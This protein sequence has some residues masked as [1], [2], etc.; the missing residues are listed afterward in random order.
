MVVP[1]QAKV[2][3]ITRVEN[4]A[5]IVATR[6]LLSDREMMRRGGPP[7]TI[8]MSKLKRARLALP[9]QC[10][11]GDF[12]GDYVPF[13]F[14]PRSVMLY[15]LHKGNH[16]DVEYHGGQEPIVHLEADLR[17]VISWSNTH[18][19][20]WAFSLSNAASKYAEFR[21]DAAHLHEIRWASVAASDWQAQE[22]KEGKQAEF[23][24]HCFFPWELVDRI[25]VYSTRTAR[26]AGSLVAAATHRP[27]IEVLPQWY[28]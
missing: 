24:V 1:E 26:A 5:P 3:H 9:V 8:G 17:Q 21:A 19:R 11:P 10:H 16:A 27:P 4:L 15:I 2:Y 7:E 22:V 13:Y 20:K 18:Q 28:Y 12:V 6:G 14:C 25:G 23:L